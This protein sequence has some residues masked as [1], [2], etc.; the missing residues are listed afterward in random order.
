MNDF[1]KQFA[2]CPRCGGTA[3]VALYTESYIGNH[4]M[5]VVCDYCGLQLDY[6]T[7]LTRAPEVTWT[8]VLQEDRDIFDVWGNGG[9]DE[10]KPD[11]Q[12]G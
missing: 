5:R 4:S 7:S 10:F 2:P 1:D 9:L 8:Y 11:E 12:G 6:Y 3:Y